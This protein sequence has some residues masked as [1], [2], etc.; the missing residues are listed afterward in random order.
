MT[1]QQ[2][3][4]WQPAGK[5]VA[6]G[7]R[8]HMPAWMVIAGVAAG[9]AGAIIMLVASNWKESAES[10]G[11]PTGI[12]TGGPGF[13]SESYSQ[14]LSSGR[15]GRP[16]PF[17]VGGADLRCRTG[18]GRIDCRGGAPMSWG[19]RKRFTLGPFSLN[20]SKRGASVG[21]KLG[22]PRGL[23]AP[24]RYLRCPTALP[25]FQHRRRSEGCGHGTGAPRRLRAAKSPVLD[26]GVTFLGQPS[27]A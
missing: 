9:I 14:S 2:Q 1:Q 25:P 17:R 22:R 27:I 8:S 7:S 5:E 26:L 21:A 4:E 13:D 24:A 18:A 15:C 20:L 11:E 10:V 12:L 6:G 16:R 23:P 3:P 19:F